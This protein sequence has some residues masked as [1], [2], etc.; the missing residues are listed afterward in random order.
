[1]YNDD[2]TIDIKITMREHWLPHFLGMLH[3][4]EYL[5]NVGS[6]R[7]VTLFSDGDGDFRPKF[8]W[9]GDLE[10]APAREEE[11]NTSFLTDDRGHR[12]WDA[13]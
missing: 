12:W 9:D 4:M 1:M 3:H 8:Q 6:S 10:M 5:G 13:G 7:M 11:A 2:V